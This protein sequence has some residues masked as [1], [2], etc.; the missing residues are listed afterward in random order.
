MPQY[1]FVLQSDN[2]NASSTRRAVRSH[3]MKAVRRQQRQE[4]AKAFSLKWPEEQ[5]LG[6]KLQLTWPEEQS[7]EFEGPEKGAQ[8]EKRVREGT[9][10]GHLFGRVPLQASL[11]PVGSLDD[12]NPLQMG[13]QPD[14]DS[15]YMDPH[16]EGAKSLY[17]SM[18]Q[19][20]SQCAT[21]EDDEEIHPSSTSARTLLGAGRMDPFQTFPVRADVSMS[22]LIDHYITIMPATFYGVRCRKPIHRELYRIAIS[23][24]ASIHAM[25]A[26]ASKSLDFLRCSDASSLTLNHTMRAVQGVNE[27]LLATNHGQDDRDDGVMLSIAM[28]AFAE[29]GFES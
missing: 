27:G 10:G 23:H 24:Q 18:R 1:S 2:I 19:A 8:L 16:S 3:A 26:Y 14:Q 29:V 11:E 6:K 9:P 17:P 22:E 21:A 12:Y 20:P 7:P 15:L 13:F 4:N 5:P 28:L 25:I